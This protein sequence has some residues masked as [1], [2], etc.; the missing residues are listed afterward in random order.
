M[1]AEIFLYRAPI[2]TPVRTSFGTMV[3]RPSVL[4]RLEDAEGFTGW[5][6]VWCNYPAVG[7]DYRARLLQSL[8]LPLAG[9]LGSWSDPQGMWA[10]LSRRLR[11]LALQSGETGPI[12]QCL[13]G[14]ECA[15]QDLAARRAGKPLYR[16]PSEH[17]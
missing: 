14:L 11:I 3:D 7:A 5:G 6:E 10:A 9:A 12:A 17:A 16:L 13:A 2:A 4:I 8:V 1:R 15:L